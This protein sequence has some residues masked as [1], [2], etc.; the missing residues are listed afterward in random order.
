VNNN[1]RWN[2]VQSGLAKYGGANSYAG[3]AGFNG[4]AFDPPFEF[5]EI[6]KSMG[7]FSKKVTKPDELPG[8]LKEAIDAVKGGTSAVL[9]TQV[10]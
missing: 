6:A 4:S 3:K 8:A 9:D 10:L 1:H 5:A 7:A 2:A